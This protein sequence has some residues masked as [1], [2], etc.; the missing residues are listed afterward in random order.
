[1]KNSTL[2][3]VVFLLVSINVKAQLPLNVTFDNGSYSPL[4]LRYGPNDNPAQQDSNYKVSVIDGKAH[5][6]S[7]ASAPQ[8]RL[9]GF[10]DLPTTAVPI[11]GSFNHRWTFTN[12]SDFN[13]L[14]TNGI[15]GCYIRGDMNHWTGGLFGDY[16]FG[17]I[18]TATGKVSGIRQGTTNLQTEPFTAIDSVIYEI[19]KIG[20]SK[21][22]LW[23]KYDNGNWHQVGN[24]ITISLNP[25]TINA[26]YNVAVTHVRIL[27]NN[28][29]AVD[30]SVD[31]MM[32]W[33]TG[34]TAS[35]N[36]NTFQHIKIY[37]NPTQSIINIETEENSLVKIFD[38]NGKLLVNQKIENK[39]ID[40]SQLISGVYTVQIINKNKAYS[41]E[42]IKL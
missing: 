22:Q 33:N 40:V 8:I 12:V 21:L 10:L 29:N 35:V 42:I 20:D 39:Q 31:N 7:P 3:F 36:R 19:R 32:W 27:N 4:L 30:V 24:E 11:S 38:L 18:V 25:A 41:Q 37:P 15:A 14:G 13:S 9:T 23:A 1:M 2:I 6:I 28:G 5:F 34:N 26:N 17:M 16:W